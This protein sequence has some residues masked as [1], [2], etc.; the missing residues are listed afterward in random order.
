MC[1][2]AEW[3]HLVRRFE[4]AVEG[5]DVRDCVSEAAARIDELIEAVMGWACTSDDA[6]SVRTH[7]SRSG[8]ESIVV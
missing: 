7:A 1:S 2:C 3:E 5:G 6:E 4:Q 8:R